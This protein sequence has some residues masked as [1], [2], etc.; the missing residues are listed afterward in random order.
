MAL[1]SS[2]RL[3]EVQT[4]KYEPDRAIAVSFTQGV[5]ELEARGKMSILAVSCWKLALHALTHT[6]ALADPQPHAVVLDLG[7]KLCIK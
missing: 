1:Q 2:S 6:F 7:P 4:E 3:L 5:S